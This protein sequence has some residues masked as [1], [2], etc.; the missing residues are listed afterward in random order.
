LLLLRLAGPSA[1]PSVAREAAAP[2]P[3]RVTARADR[4]AVVDPAEP[5]AVTVVADDQRADRGDPAA[6]HASEQQH[7]RGHQQ[8]HPPPVPPLAGPHD[9]WRRVTGPGVTGRR[10]VDRLS[11]LGRLFG[12]RFGD[13]RLLDGRVFL[14]RR[15]GGIPAWY[16][17]THGYRPLSEDR[18]DDGRTKPASPA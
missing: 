13:R 4:S 6:Q 16:F 10:G 2:V 1:R 11:R 8:R 9:R 12:G 18:L 17:V 3:A 5:A 7:G 15:I 14:R